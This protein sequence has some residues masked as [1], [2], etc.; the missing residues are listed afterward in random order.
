MNALLTD[1]KMAPNRMSLPRFR[2]EKLGGG[3]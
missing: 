1:A 2:V 3:S